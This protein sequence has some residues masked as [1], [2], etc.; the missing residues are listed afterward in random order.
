MNNTYG[1][2]KSKINKKRE[3]VKNMNEAYLVNRKRGGDVKSSEN[4]L[5]KSPGC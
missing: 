4:M 3:D 2:M 5:E 1:K